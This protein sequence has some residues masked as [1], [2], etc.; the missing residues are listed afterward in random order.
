MAPPPLEMA[1]DTGVAIVV[2]AVGCPQR[3]GRTLIGQGQINSS[4]DWNIRN[5]HLIDPISLD[6]MVIG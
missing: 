1:I 6:L 5:V 4:S 2:V 3:R